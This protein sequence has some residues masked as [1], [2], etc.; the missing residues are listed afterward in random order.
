MQDGLAARKTARAQLLDVVDD[1]DRVLVGQTQQKDDAQQRDHAEVGLRD[2]QAQHRADDAQRQRCDHHHG[3]EQAAKKHEQQH[4]DAQQ[5]QAQRLEKAADDFL[6]LS[7]L[8]AEVETDAG[9]QRRLCDGHRTVSS[10]AHGGVRPE[11]GRDQRHAAS[12]VVLNLERC[13]AVHLRGAAADVG[14][15]E[16]PVESFG[17][18]LPGLLQRH[19]VISDQTQLHRLFATAIDEGDV[20]D[21]GADPGQQRHLATEFFLQH[22]G[23][24]VPVG[25]QL[26]VDLALVGFALTRADHGECGFDR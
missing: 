18:R 2:Q 20:F 14:Q 19:K 6:G 7:G 22:R 24:G 25:L 26:N 23:G 13:A 10:F 9:R 3:I 21:A 12:V 17:Q 8:S 15:P 1:Q 16:H 5:R 11:V 4:K